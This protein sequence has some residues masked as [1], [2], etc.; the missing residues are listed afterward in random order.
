MLSS[1]VGQITSCLG[2]LWK[3]ARSKSEICWYISIRI[4]SVDRWTGHHRI[5][6][7]CMLSAS[8]GQL[9]LLS[10]SFKT[11]CVPEVALTL[12]QGHCC[13]T[14]GEL[15]WRTLDPSWPWH[16][17][18]DLR[19][20]IELSPAVGRKSL[21]EEPGALQQTYHR[22]FAENRFSSCAVVCNACPWNLK[23]R[24]FNDIIFPAG[25]RTGSAIPLPGLRY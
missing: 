22:G 8:I 17:C 1:V 5:T 9:S 20:E 6:D 10:N 7:N 14:Q 25:R 3:S 4:F 12:I 18:F 11:L 24:M 19:K 23:P 15:R 2:H 21:G 13:Q 16:E